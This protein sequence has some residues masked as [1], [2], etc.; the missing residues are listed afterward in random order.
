MPT[1]VQNAI[2]PVVFAGERRQHVLVVDNERER[3][4]AEHAVQHV[5]AGQS[6]DA[7]EPAG[8]AAEPHAFKHPYVGVDAGGDGREHRTVHGPSVAHGI[9]VNGMGTTTSAAAHTNTA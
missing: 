2:S 9:A 5:D 6:Y 3:P 1:N 8:S 7:V 4:G